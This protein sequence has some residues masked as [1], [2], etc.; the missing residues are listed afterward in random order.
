MND[1]N[2]KLLA[3]EAREIT[4]LDSALWLKYLYVTFILILP[5]FW[6]FIW[7]NDLPE[8]EFFHIT[9]DVTLNISR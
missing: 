5:S 9:F 1:A 3:L 2:A 6:I 8:N 4:S 7:Y